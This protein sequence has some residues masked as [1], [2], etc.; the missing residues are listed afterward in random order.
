MQGHT[1]KELA[2][3]LL[4]FFKVHDISIADCRGQSYD[5][6][7]NMSGK[8]NGMQAI[9][10]Q[11]CNLAE[12]VPCD[13]HS[14]NLV[15]QTAIGCCTLAIGFFRFLQGLYSFFSAS[16]HRWKV[17]M[18]QL[19]SEGLP[20]VKRMSDTRWSAR[21]DATK[22]LVEGYDEINDTLVEIVGKEEEKTETREEARGLAAKM[23]QLETGILA[24]LWHHILHHFHANSQA[25]QSADQDLNSAVAIYESLIDFIG[26]QRERFE[27]FEAE[28]KK[29]SQ[30]DQYVG[31]EKRV[32]KRNRRYDEPGSAPELSQTPTNKFHTDTFLVI[33]D[34]IDAELRKR[35]GAYTGIAARFGFLRKLKDL[36]VEEVVENAKILQEE[37]PT[38]QE[39]SLSDELVQLSSF[40]CTDFAMKSLDVTTASATSS[41]AINDTSS[42]KSDDL[43]DDNVTLNVDSLELRM[44]RLLENNLETA[45]PNILITLRIYLSLMISNCSGERSFS[46][47][48]LIKNQLRSCMTQKRLNSLTL[49]S[50]ENYLLRNNVVSSIINGFA[51]KKSR[52]HNVLQSLCRMRKISYIA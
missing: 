48:K 14:L 9:I 10:R 20:T 51:L 33:I 46:K 40:L 15:G 28:G 5:N 52:K 35:L 18:G 47:L 16:P 36:S 32:R 38:D 37:Y 24:T 42:D 34:R 31:E 41:Q 1:G 8:Y 13:A 43:K 11:Q 19:S 49:L 39:P 26:K 29:L 21:A 22:A 44:Y 30:C 3:S 27:E 2:E 12:Y 7:S 17:L 45:F 50:I 23:N 6:A 25:L 4:E